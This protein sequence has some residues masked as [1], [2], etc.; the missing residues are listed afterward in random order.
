MKSNPVLLLS[1]ILVLLLLFSC[2]SSE[3]KT[4]TAVRN[5]PNVV[6]I[7]SDDQG[8]TD[9]SFMGHPHTKTPRID[10]LAA[11]GLTFTRGYVAAP[12]CRPSLASI[13]T[14]LYPH[15]HGVISNDPVVSGIPMETKEDRNLYKKNHRPS[16]NKP[17]VDAFEKL[18]T[19]ADLMCKKGYLS[20]QTGKWWEGHYSQGG[21][22]HGMTHGD[23]QR[24]GRHGDAGLTIGREGMQEIY[25]FIDLAEK[26]DKPFFVWYAP[27]LPHAPHFPPDSLL[28]KYLQVAPNEP[29]ARYWACCEWFDITCGQLIDH[30]DGRGLGK[31]TLIIYVTDNGWIQHPELAHKSY[32]R[33]KRSPYEMGIRTPIIFRWT[34][35]IE[36][37]MDTTTL[38]SS[39]DIATTIYKVCGIEGPENLQ[40]LDALDP[41][42]LQAREE[43]FAEGLTH[44]PFTEESSPQYR[45]IITNPWKLILPD[46]ITM[47][48]EELQ[49]YNVFEDVHETRNLAPDHPGIVAGLKA[50]IEDWLAE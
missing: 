13:V 41:E 37:E 35:M 24:G 49:L 36:P 44:D 2:G 4:T 12:L 8:W 32:R 17:V 31:N 40:G 38:V 42:V 15:Q 43:I 48:E 11:E 7:I 3:K 14:G 6:L 33:S 34:G 47:P 9:Y 50:R 20:L 16:L 25:D 23:P 19:L 30:L 18:T 45:V 26:A 29:V 27:L 39:V 46:P 1:A 21:F 5:L 28:Q 10:R 22:T